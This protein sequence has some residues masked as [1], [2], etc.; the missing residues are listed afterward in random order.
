MGYECLKQIFFVKFGAPAKFQPASEHEAF[1]KKFFIFEGW[2]TTLWNFRSACRSPAATISLPAQPGQR[3]WH[4][5]LQ[6]G[7]QL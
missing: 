2:A 4:R 7:R 3:T 6:I 1:E 5:L